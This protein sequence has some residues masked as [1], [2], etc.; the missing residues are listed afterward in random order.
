MTTYTIVFWNDL[1][2]ATVP[3]G[4]DIDAAVSAEAERS[5]CPEMEAT[6]IE[7]GLTLTNDVIDGDEVM[8]SGVALG[9]L[10]NERGE[11]FRYAVRR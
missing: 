7:S 10:E 2:V 11:N 4:G 6:S 1:L 9:W 8:Y 5:G 3:D